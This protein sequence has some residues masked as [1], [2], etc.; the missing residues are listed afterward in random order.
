MP[1]LKLT[2]RRGTTAF[3][4]KWSGKMELD[5]AKLLLND[6]A[7]GIDPITGEVLPDTSP[8]NAPRVRPTRSHFPAF[9]QR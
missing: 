7:N 2:N 8:Y 5:E 1:V 9:Q 6:L 4:E 3:A